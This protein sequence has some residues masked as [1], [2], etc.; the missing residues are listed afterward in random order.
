MVPNL[1][2]DR[3]GGGGINQERPKI[4]VTSQIQIW[5]EIK[6]FP[7]VGITPSI[8]QLP[9]ADWSLSGSSYLGKNLSTSLTVP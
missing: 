4:S 8:H 5:G 3:G 2:Q 7:L 6:T 1:N 9:E